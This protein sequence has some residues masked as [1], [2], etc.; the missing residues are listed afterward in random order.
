MN[1]LKENLKLAI[2]QQ[3]WQAA[4]GISSQ[5][6]SSSNITAEYRQHLVTWRHQFSQYAASKTRFAEIPNCEGVYAEE[7]KASTN[8]VPLNSA[9]AT[10]SLPFSSTA[11]QPARPQV[12]AARPTV[13]YAYQRPSPLPAAVPEDARCYIM[14]SDGRVVNLDSLCK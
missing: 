8:S 14:Y 1:Q 12:T 10:A 6:M 13:S 4:V 9:S 2:C 3:N 11:S 7:F 5:L